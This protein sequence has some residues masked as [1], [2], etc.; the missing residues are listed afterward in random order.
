MLLAAVASGLEAPAVLALA[1]AVM[2]RGPCLWLRPAAKPREAVPPS[3]SG[4]RRAVVRSRPPRGYVA[5][6]K[7]KYLE[8]L[9]GAT[10]RR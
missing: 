2:E 4:C 5:V 3:L 1:M 7:G 10:R 6:R 9:A 8:M